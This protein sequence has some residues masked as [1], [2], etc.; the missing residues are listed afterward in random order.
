VHTG[1]RGAKSVGT[2]KP[3][4]SKSKDGHHEERFYEAEQGGEGD[5][6]VYFYA[7]GI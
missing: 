5:E 7:P 1:S 6:R 2:S 4:G 3:L